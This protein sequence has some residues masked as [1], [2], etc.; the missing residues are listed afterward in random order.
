MRGYDQTLALFLRLIGVVMLLAILPMFFPISWM[1]AV[2]ARIGLGELPSI[3]IIGYLARSLS[4]M[5]ALYGAA[6]FYLSFSV[7]ASASFLRFLGGLGILFGLFMIWMDWHV[8]LPVSWIVSEGPFIV[9]A[10]ALIA[11]LAGRVRA[12]EAA[13]GSSPRASKAQEGG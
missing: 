2:H 8:G 12:E 6:L 11:W 13:A 5:Y 3:P 9:A 1:Q 4:A 7:R 10:S